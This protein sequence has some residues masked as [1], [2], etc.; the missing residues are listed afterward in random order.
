MAELKPCLTCTKVKDPSACTHICCSEWKY[1][2]LKKWEEIYDYG[3]RYGA[4][5]GKDDG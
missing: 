2:W 5:G 3:K 1:W 4:N